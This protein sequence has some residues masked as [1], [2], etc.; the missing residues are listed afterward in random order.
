M[1]A[2]LNWVPDEV[3]IDTPS[4]ARIYDYLLG[5]S[6]NFAA[7]R[8][9]GD[10]FD[11][12]LPGSR[13]IARLNRAFLRR[14]VL[15]LVECGIRQFL[16]IGSGIPTAGNVHEL[17]RHAAADS[18]VVYVDTD[19]IAVA[20]SQ[21]LLEDNPQAIAVKADLR[22]PE[23]ILCAPQVR[24]LL[25]FS[26][27]IGLLTVWVFH[28]VPIAQ[29]AVGILRRYRDAL[30]PGSCLVV[31]HFTAD[32]R[33]AEMAA[34]VEVTKRSANP[35]HPRARAQIVELFTGFDLV[36]PGVVATALWRPEGPVGNDA[37]H[38]EVLAGVGR[39]P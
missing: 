12:A 13:D 8:A 34:M 37:D 21:L 39:K 31:S 3:D 32:S 9:L 17:A 6:H 38:D 30:A 16:D 23:S 27:P 26:Q 5:G 7:D 29:D 24:G 1:T 11:Q 28:F 20:H 2:N 14:A 22:E 15:F 36:D 18:R 25:D 33:P 19:P 35:I 10:K 4:A